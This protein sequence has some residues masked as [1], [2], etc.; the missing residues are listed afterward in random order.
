MSELFEIEVE[1]RGR[2]IRVHANGGIDVWFPVDHLQ[3]WGLIQG[4]FYVCMVAGESCL[5]FSENKVDVEQLN[6]KFSRAWDD[7]NG[8][9]D[10]ARA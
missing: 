4:G 6:E 5:S 7:A 1:A 2:L 3:A 9:Y 8:M 10:R